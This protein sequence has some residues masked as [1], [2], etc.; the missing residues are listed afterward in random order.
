MKYIPFALVASCV[1]LFLAYCLL[2]DD[3]VEWDVSTIE[4][5]CPLSCSYLDI[6]KS[7][8]DT[9]YNIL[10]IR[11]NQEPN[12]AFYQSLRAQGWQ[13]TGEA[14]THG[15]FSLHYDAG[16]KCIIIR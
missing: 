1:V 5:N 12:A 16:D 15:A 11:L 14:Y 10:T 3:V 2:F 13:P 4:R 7:F 9:D 8:F 6:D